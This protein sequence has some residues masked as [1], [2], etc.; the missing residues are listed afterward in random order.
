MNKTLIAILLVVAIFSAG[1]L[2]GAAAKP[3]TVLHVVTVKWKD[4]TTPDQIAA[5]VNGV[6]KMAADY[7]GIRR[8]WLRP[9]K[10]QGTETGVTHAFVM[11]FTS[12]KALAD[13]ADSEAQKAWYKVYLPVRELSRTFD[14]TN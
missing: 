4:G 3:T 8:I 14:I 5:A 2:L 9:I 13:Y 10:V 11:E 7:P 6:E 1:L 12:E